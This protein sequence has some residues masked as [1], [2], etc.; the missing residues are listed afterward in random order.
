[1]KASPQDRPVVSLRMIAEKIGCSRATVSMALN[2]HPE[3]SAGRREEVQRVAKALGWRPNAV[4]A[5]KLA[6][7]RRAHLDPASAVIALVLNEQRKP[8]QMTAARRQGEGATE[9]AEHLGYRIEPFYLPDESWR[10]SRLREVMRARGVDGVAFLGTL[11]PQMPEAFFTAAESFPTVVTGVHSA[12]VPYHAVSTDYLALGRLAIG[13]LRESGYRRIGVMLPRGLE[14]ALDYGYTA[15]LASASASLAQKDSVAIEYF[16]ETETHL[17]RQRTAEMLDW[18]A[19]SRPEVILTTDFAY[20]R[21]IV[22]RLHPAHVPRALFSL[23]HLHGQ[24]WRGIDQRHAEIGRRAIKLLVSQIHSSSQGRPEI[25][26][27]VTI[28]PVWSADGVETESEEAFEELQS[29][30]AKEPSNFSADP[31]EAAFE[32][33]PGAA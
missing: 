2:E 28:A 24:P 25:A 17:P 30:R 5:R 18:I 33:A 31:S 11:A 4:L 29:K 23:D 10:P 3:I 12:R 20:L 15:G 9:E 26:T 22:R 14:E 21:Q 16:G 8:S 6:L 32:S 1:M 19:S 13:R 27:T 7:L